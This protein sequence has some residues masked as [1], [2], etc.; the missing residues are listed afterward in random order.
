MYYGDYLKL[1]QLLSAQQLESE[2]K[3]RYAH[4]EMLFIVVH[5][6]YELWFKQMLHEIDSIIDVFKQN[7]VE[8]KHLFTANSRLDRVVK[9]QKLILEQI[10]IMET[11]T[12]MDFLEFRDLL[13]PASGFQ[14]VQFRELE[15]KL[16]LSTKRRFQVDQKYFTGRLSEDDQN[17]V[18]SYEKTE[19]ILDLLEAWL[20]RI[21]FVKTQDFDFWQEYQK[22]IDDLITTDEDIIKAHNQGD[23]LKAELK[24]L[25]STKQT[26]ASLFDEDIHQQMLEKGDRRMS[27]E[28]LLSALFILLYRDEPILYQ[29][30]ELLTHLMNIDEQITT[31]RYKH[32]MMAHRMLGSK[33]GTGG[34]SGH[35]Y[36]KNTTSHN[37]VFIDL[38]NLSTFLIPRSKLPKLPEHL[39]KKL[40]YHFNHE[41]L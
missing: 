39:I 25:E 24:R 17:K 16:G 32:A 22:V 2:K 5:Q 35:Q 28:A 8:E 30:F 36:L 6:A 21:P 26:F 23:E 37:R 15:I 9:I 11:M 41:D 40:N 34:S 10:D 19:N 20:E 29:P 12:P 7:P 33:I 18:H 13:V 1:D 14:S 27:R 31:W 3:G 38:F 4:D